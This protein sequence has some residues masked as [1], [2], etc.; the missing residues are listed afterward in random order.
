MAKAPTIR[1]WGSVLAALRQASGLSAAEVVERLK[2]L[3]VEINRASIYTYEAG[4]VSAPDAGVVWGLSQIYCVPVA[5][6]IADLVALRK[7]ESRPDRP[8]TSAS[9]KS[10]A[11]EHLTEAEIEWVQQWRQLT[12]QARKACRE[13]IRFQLNS[14]PPTPNQPQRARAKSSKSSRDL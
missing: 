9:G 14:N 7:G 6:L 11:N 8:K 1:N 5:D 3:G 10:D 2:T 12:P 4:R 13:F